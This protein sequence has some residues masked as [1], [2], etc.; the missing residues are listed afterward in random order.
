M[1]PLVGVGAGADTGAQ[2]AEATL[3][4]AAGVPATAL[5]VTR[6]PIMVVEPSALVDLT[7]WATV[8]FLPT[9]PAGVPLTLA[10]TTPSMQVTET[11]DAETSPPKAV[12]P[13]TLALALPPP[14]RT[15]ADPMVMV[16]SDEDA[17][18]EADRCCPSV[19]LT[20]G[21]ALIGA[22]P[23]AEIPKAES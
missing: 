7:P 8:P 17:A 22:A 12:N 2:V 21:F 3:M 20:A 16:P 14:A 6:I 9:A 1:V 11:L 4:T 5:M 18:P 15:V 13:V 23:V 10:V 19:L